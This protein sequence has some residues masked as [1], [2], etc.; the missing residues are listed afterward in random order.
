MQLDKVKG[1][2]SSHLIIEMSLQCASR[3]FGPCCRGQVP[4]VRLYV[5]DGAVGRG[6]RAACTEA[7]GLMALGESRTIQPDRG[8]SCVN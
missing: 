4:E 7:A 5:L 8:D 6:L 3:D 1:L 2:L